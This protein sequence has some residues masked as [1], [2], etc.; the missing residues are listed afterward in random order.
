MDFVI[1][2]NTHVFQDLI[3][4]D[5]SKNHVWKLAGKSDTHCSRNG[6]ARISGLRCLNAMGP[7]LTGTVGPSVWYLMPGTPWRRSPRS[8]F[9]SYTPKGPKY[10]YGRKYG[11]CSSN[12]PYGLGKYSLYGYFGPFGYRQQATYLAEAMFLQKMAVGATWVV[13]LAFVSDWGT[14][15]T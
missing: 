11:F 15:C 12:F 3:G 8:P 2:S 7:F 4:Q 14:V 9:Q 5:H 10:L 13:A 6:I 1:V